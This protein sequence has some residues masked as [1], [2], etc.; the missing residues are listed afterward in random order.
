MQGLREGFVGLSVL[1]LVRSVWLAYAAR[2]VDLAKLT[3]TLDLESEQAAKNMPTVSVMITQIQAK[4]PVNA[5][6]ALAD[7]RSIIGR[8]S[9]PMCMRA[10]IPCVGM[11]KATRNP[12]C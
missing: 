10:F 4:A 7:S 2:E 1:A 11:P 3:A 12:C 5:Y 8:R 9:I 6:D